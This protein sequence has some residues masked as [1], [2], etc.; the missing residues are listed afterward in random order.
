MREEGRALV[1][2]VRAHA[3]AP[4][5]ERQKAQRALT[6][7]LHEQRGTIAT[8]ENALRPASTDVITPPKIGD[9]VEAKNGKIRG[10]L[11]AVNGQRARI[12]SGGLTFDLALAQLRKTAKTKRE[13]IIHVAVRRPETVQSEINLLGLR[14]NEALSRLAEFLDQAMLNRQSSV[15]I[16]HGF[17]TG[18]L[19]RAVQD[20]L[21]QSPYCSSYNEAPQNEGGGGATIA[22]LAG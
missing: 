18:A 4:Q 12:R 16:I 22:N 2:Q 15:R 5:A 11:V 13:Q 10:E 3:R 14:V 21:S 17:G 1:A 19:R 8:R 7:F 6:Q 20:F 9:Q